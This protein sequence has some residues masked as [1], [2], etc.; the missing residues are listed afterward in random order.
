M[1]G[2]CDFNENQVVHL[3]LDFNLGFVNFVVAHNQSK[4]KVL[5]KFKGDPLGLQQYEEKQIEDYQG[6]LVKHKGRMLVAGC[7]QD[8]S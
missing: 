8:Q 1:V 5:K 2:N 7:C 6:V 3:D 4:F